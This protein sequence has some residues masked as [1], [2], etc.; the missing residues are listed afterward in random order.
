[1]KPTTFTPVDPTGRKTSEDTVTADDL[2]AAK[3][4]FGGDTAGFVNSLLKDRFGDAD[5]DPLSEFGGSVSPF[6]YIRPF[7]AALAYFG[8]RFNE[9]FEDLKT[10]AAILQTAD[11]KELYRRV[12]RL[13]EES[14]IS[15]L[16]GGGEENLQADLEKL[17]SEH[18]TMKKNYSTIVYQIPYLMQYLPESERK[19]LWQ[20]LPNDIKEIYASN[21]FRGYNSK[22]QK[23][24]S[25][26]QKNNTYQTKLN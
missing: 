17:K 11:T 1:M 14:I 8:V 2:E 18:E 24:G 15:G 23:R 21:L 3:K 13:S 16:L 19:E 5:A 20:Y 7:W 26:P 10:Y 25:F 22:N 4:L 9:S 6:D 12:T